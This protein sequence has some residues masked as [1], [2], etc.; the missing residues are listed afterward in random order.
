[1]ALKTEREKK[2]AMY[3]PMRKYAVKA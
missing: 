1:L 3:F 2:R